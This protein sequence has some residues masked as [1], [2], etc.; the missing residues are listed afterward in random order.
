MTYLFR[1]KKKT[2]Q[3]SIQPFF[4]IFLHQQAGFTGKLFITSRKP[5]C[6]T[7]VLTA[8]LRAGLLPLFVKAVSTV[9]Y[10]RLPRKLCSYLLPVQKIT[11]S[12]R[13]SI[14]K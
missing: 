6:D 5:R 9:S 2:V 3:P 13:I 1:K 4:N 12:R 11:N 8:L 7:V 10:H 14:L